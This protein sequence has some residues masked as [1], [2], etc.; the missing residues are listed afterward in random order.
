[1]YTIPVKTLNSVPNMILVIPGAFSINFIVSARKTT[2]AMSDCR[3]LLRFAAI[4][5]PV[6][7][8]R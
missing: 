6:I 7:S 3:N 5:L 4:M 1:M 8:F 2:F